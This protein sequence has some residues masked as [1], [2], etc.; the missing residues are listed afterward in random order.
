MHMRRLGL[1]ELTVSTL[2]LGG[3]VFGWSAD[4]AASFKVLDAYVAAGG[5]FVDTADVYSSWVPGNVGGESEAVI[6]RWM[7]SRGNRQAIVLTT[8][9]GSDMGPGRKGLSRA[10]VREAVEASLKRMQTDVI[11]LYL[12]HWEDPDTALEETLGVF[13]ELVKEGKV[14]AIGNSNHSAATMRRAQEI[15]AREGWP[16]FENLQTHYNLYDRKGYEGELEAFCAANKVGV[17]TYFSLA[18]G[19]LSGKY[20]TH[21]DLG[22]SAARGESMK[23]YLN[24]RGH[25]ILRALDTVAEGAKATPAQVAIAWIIARPGIT[26]AVASATGTEQLA[27]LVA[28]TQ[29]D[30]SAEAVQTLDAASG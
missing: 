10:Y 28:A 23:D 22:K 2:C 6:G 5:N 12:A 26:A 19:F 18:R 1:S 9:V 15:S 24:D 13:A 25:R 7:K 4:E 17:T 20:R 8:K 16:R 3:N 21:K 29:L 11:D 14:R 30:L 27:D